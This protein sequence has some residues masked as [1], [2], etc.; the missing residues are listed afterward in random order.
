MLAGPLLDWLG[1]WG[2]AISEHHERFDGKGYPLG[3]AGHEIAQAAR[4]VAVADSFE[5]M[6][7]VRSYK[8]PMSVA[9][10]RRE[11]A[12]VAGTQLD[13]ACV[14]AF[15]GASLPRVLW[16]VGPLALLVN[17]PVLRGV[18]EAGRVVEHAGVAVAG[19][20]ATVAVAA[21]TAAVLAVPGVSP[22][23]DLRQPR[24]PAH[25][26]RRPCERHRRRFRVARP[27]TAA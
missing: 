25:G 2:A 8:R 3:L 20:A 23:R 1:E 18:A 13:P 27:G 5:V 26:S 9:A 14:R 22:G 12:D 15:L 4:I 17:L 16:A 24:A 19:Q 6:T 7:A 10:A 11:L 21:T